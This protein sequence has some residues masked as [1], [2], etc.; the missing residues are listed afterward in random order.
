MFSR[1]G[2]SLTTL[3]GFA[4]KTWNLGNQS[5]E[6]AVPGFAISNGLFLVTAST[7][8]RLVVVNTLDGLNHVFDTT[9]W[10]ELFAF[11]DPPRFVGKLEA[12]VLT[13]Q[14]RL[15]ITASADGTMHFYDLEQR[16]TLDV[17]RVSGTRLSELAVSPEGKLLAIAARDTRIHLWDLQ[18][19]TSLGSLKG[20]RQSVWG[21]SFSPDGRR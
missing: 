4:F 11:P 5:Q 16:R 6:K 8:Q 1:D 17:R 13:P 19:H 9:G 21:V 12:Q 2:Q 18:P 20:H 14:N 15:V 3:D 7:D 10:Q